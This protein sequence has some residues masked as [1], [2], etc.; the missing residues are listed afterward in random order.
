MDTRSHM[1]AAPDAAN[2]L[3]VRPEAGRSSGRSA[4]PSADCAV[5][6][7]GLTKTYR[8]NWTLKTTRGLEHLNLEVQRGEVF[9]YLGPNGAGKTTTL[10]IL[11]GL[12]KP[13]SGHAWLL[14]EPIEHVRSRVRL[15]FLPEQP[16][17]YDYLNGVE[18][19]EFVAQLSGMPGQEATKA[20]R[21][22]LGRVGLGDREKL[23]LRK[24][25]KGMLQR[26]GLAAAL[27]HEP[28]LVIL[29]EPMSGLDPF[30]RRDVRDLILEQRERGVTV[31]FSSHIL[32]D[33]EMLCDRVAILL[34][35]RLERVATVGELVNGAG[36]R[37]EFR[38]AGA[39]ILELPS[40][41]SARLTRTQ[42]AEE[43]LF[44][45]GDA[46]LQQEVLAWLVSQRVEVRAVTPQRNTLEELFMAAAESSAIHASRERRSA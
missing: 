24:Y 7:S 25:S 20:A 3:A 4:L 10:K 23:V 40:A 1:E 22:W 35:G 41:W 46:S 16:Y 12:L 14:G 30:G 45:L 8:S 9:G 38:C 31:M 34:R 19:L 11:T 33:V 26:L 44:T 18:Y 42:R 15:G 28:E 6:I 27:V 36:A 21:R 39:P 17:F 5:R 29:D 2:A 43:T 37:V 13:T 32:P